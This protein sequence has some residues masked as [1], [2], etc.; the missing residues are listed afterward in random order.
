V[1][2]SIG[3]VEDVEVLDRGEIWIAIDGEG[4]AELGANLLGIGRV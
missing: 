4:D 1:S 3:F 2:D